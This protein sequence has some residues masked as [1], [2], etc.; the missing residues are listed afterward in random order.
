MTRHEKDEE[1]AL[2]DD[3]SPDFA[4]YCDILL[5]LVLISSLSLYNVNPALVHYTRLSCSPSS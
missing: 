1:V 4:L 3:R 5:V 2:F